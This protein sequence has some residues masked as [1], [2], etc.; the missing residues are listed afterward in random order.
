MG[1]FSRIV[2]HTWYCREGQFLSSFFNKD[3]LDERF[4]GSISVANIPFIQGNCD[5]EGTLFSL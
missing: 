2:L 1:D 3:E 5:D 4:Y